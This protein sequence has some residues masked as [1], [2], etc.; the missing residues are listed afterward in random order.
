[1]VNL[2]L[3]DDARMLKDSAERFMADKLPVKELRRVR[4]TE[5]ADGF[6]RDAH[7]IIP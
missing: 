5:D 6:S 7:H 2:V 4:D 3:D 1:M